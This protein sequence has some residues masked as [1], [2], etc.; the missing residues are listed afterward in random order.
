[1]LL[2][3]I[4]MSASDKSHGEIK[5]GDGDW[6]KPS[7]HGLICPCCGGDV[8]KLNDPER[9][10]DIWACIECNFYWS[11]SVE[12]PIVPDWDSDGLG[13][14][15]DNCPDVANPDQADTD[16]DGVGD[17]CD[18]CPDVANADQADTDADGVGD[19][20]DNCPDVA[21]ADQADTDGDGV[22]DACD[23]CPD[24][25]NPDQA[26]TDADG[27][28]DA[29]DNCPEV[30]NADQADT[31]GD[32]VGDA[33]D[34]C[35]DVANADQADTDGD[36]VGDACEVADA[37]NDGV[38]DSSD[39]CPFVY[40]PHQADADGDGVGD[41]CDDLGTGD[42]QITLTWPEHTDIDLHV[43]EP[44]GEEIWYYHTTSLTG[45]QLDRDNYCYNWI[46]GYPE[47]VFWPIDG[48][49]TGTYFVNVVYYDD[50]DLIDGVTPSNWIVRTLVGGVE[51]FY[52]GTITTI[53]E[54][55]NVVS[56]TI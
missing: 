16:A 38:P 39:N 55:Q 49:P 6:D 12:K 17:A 40:N 4:G 26:D 24:V 10:G 23:N 18:N 47:N 43:I 28:G 50:C 41:A 14:P 9:G 34:N 48:S 20:C 25:A 31:D 15:C 30:A 1:M 2:I 36:G 27:V 42:V 19:A 11:T 46:S 33:C 53:G 29:C 35:P 5:P 3:T 22:G 37:D 52:Y 45:G 32:G 7:V 44:S 13:D 21:N 8:E 54:T 56:F 51:T